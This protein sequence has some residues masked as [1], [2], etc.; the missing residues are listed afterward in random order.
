MWTK[1]LLLCSVS[2]SV[3]ILLAEPGDQVR[4]LAVGDVMLSRHVRRIAFEHK[5]PSWPFRKVAPMLAA[6]DITFANLESPFFD[7]G[8]PAPLNIMVFKA[9]PEMIEGLTLAGID[10]V[11]TANNHS[12]DYGPHSISFTLDH[13]RKNGIEPV[14]TGID[15][16]QAHAGAVLERKGTKFGFLAYA[17]DQ[18]N[19]NWPDLDPRVADMDIAQM[20][21][22]VANIRKTADV[23]I[24]SMHAGMEYSAAVHPIQVAFAH[25][26]IEAGATVVLG[27]HP[28]VVQRVEPYRG[29][30]IFYSLGNFVFDQ[31]RKDANMGIVAEIT[32]ER[33]VLKNYRTLNVAIQDTVPE[34]GKPREHFP[35]EE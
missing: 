14:G 2:A 7:Q 8:P 16:A 15:F 34:I 21:K 29:G 19:G 6:A 22:D 33:G 3:L 24:I 30:V 11:S 1:Q 23:V 20:W 28:H 12:R 35:I 17:F 4:I 31:Q 25:A 27:H 9:P 10:V 26:A 13:L 5:D 32:F 18:R